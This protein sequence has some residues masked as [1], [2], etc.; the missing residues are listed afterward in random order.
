RYLHD[1]L[2]IYEAP[3]KEKQDV[4]HIGSGRS[5]RGFRGNGF[6]RGFGF[7]E[8][9]P[10]ER[11]RLSGEGVRRCKKPGRECDTNRPVQD[12][13]TYVSDDSENVYRRR[14]LS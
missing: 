9:L 8:T 13:I 1:A 4:T 3:N 7:H 14:E 12:R 11:L 5:D 2:P 6:G 10:D